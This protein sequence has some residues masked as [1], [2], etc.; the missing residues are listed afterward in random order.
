M[1]Q[2]T[3]A[4]LVASPLPPNFS[5]VGP[6]GF[7]QALIRYVQ[8]VI[9]GTFTGVIRGTID[10]S[11]DQGLF[12]NSLQRVFKDWDVGTGRYQPVTDLSL[13]EEKVFYTPGD[14]LVKGWVVLNG[15]TIN[16]IT[17][18]SVLQK[19]VLESVFGPGG[20]LPN[21]IVL[22][23]FSNLPANGAF[24]GITIEDILP[25][26]GEIA[27]LTFDTPHPT[28]EQTEALRDKTE[29]LRD[30]A[31]ALKDD[32]VAIRDVA[33]QLLDSVR[34]SASATVTAYAK[35]WVGFPE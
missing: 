13:T 6:D 17:G 5:V 16:S 21:R 11:N 15:R 30:S 1:A 9:P 14:D 31:A 4:K 7:L 20:S 27:A 29:V 28:K 23:A 3:F 18:L 35:I 19:Q 2:N 10:P 34:A 12:Y 24:G 26:N 25:A 22:G 32:T 33:E 8:V